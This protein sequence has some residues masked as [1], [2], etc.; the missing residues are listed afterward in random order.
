MIKQHMVLVCA[1]AALAAQDLPLT[2][3]LTRSTSDKRLLDAIVWVTPLN[4]NTRPT[5]RCTGFVSAPNVITTALECVAGA[6][7]VELTF[8][9]G[10][11]VRVETLLR[12][13]P[14]RRWVQLSAS[15]VETPLPAGDPRK[16]Q[17]EDALQVFSVEAHDERSVLPV[18]VKRVRKPELG[19]YFEIEPRPSPASVG[20]PVLNDDGQVVGVLVTGGLRQT[21]NFDLSPWPRYAVIVDEKAPTVLPTR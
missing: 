11:R 17:N 5:D 14:A 9:D 18:G 16:V 7:R 2:R 10:R 19:E 3:M 15:T 1:C 8:R 20:G 21:V 6:T 4:A 13:D 12:Y